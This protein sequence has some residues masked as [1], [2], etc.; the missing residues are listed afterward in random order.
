MPTFNPKRA[1]EKGLFFRFYKGDQKR[2]KN[3]NKLK[4]S[5]WPGITVSPTN[6]QLPFGIMTKSLP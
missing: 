3:K 5:G 4:A 6:V 1:T 2:E